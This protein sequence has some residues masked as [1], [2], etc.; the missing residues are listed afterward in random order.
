MF[1]DH[2]RICGP[3]LAETSLWYAWLYN[4]RDNSPTISSMPIHTQLKDY[5]KE[6]SSFRKRNHTVCCNFT[7]P[8]FSAH[9]ACYTT[10][11]FVAGF[12]DWIVFVSDI[13]RRCQLPTVFSV[14]DRL[15][16]EYAAKVE[17]YRQET[18][19][20]L[21]EKSVPL[22]LFPPNTSRAVSW[23]WS[24]SSAVSRRRVLRGPWHSAPSE[25]ELKF[26][27]VLENLSVDDKIFVCVCVCVCVC[28]VC[29]CVCVWCVCVVCVYVCGVCV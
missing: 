14:G 25:A 21:R 28:G 12:V 15:I 26:R 27:I 5:K 22:S 24:P 3:S 7:V 16:N 9:T 10:V 23:E 4:R 17:W 19:E 2:C 11:H 8:I 1:W 29:V 20:L 13:Y 6:S 18:T